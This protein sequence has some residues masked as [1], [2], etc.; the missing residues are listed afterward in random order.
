MVMTLPLVRSSRLFVAVLL[1][2]GLVA[3]ATDGFAQP[4]PRGGDRPVQRTLSRKEIYANLSNELGVKDA[5]AKAL[6]QSVEDRGFPPRETVV[7]LL[8][9]KARADRLIEEGKVSKGQGLDALHASVDFLVGLV[10][11]EKAGWL[12]LVQKTG[13]QVDLTAVVARANQI[14]GFFSERAG[15]SRTVPVRE[16]P[17]ALKPPASEKPAQETPAKQE[18]QEEQKDE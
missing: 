4:P 2:A 3:S 10:E 15:V 5:E 18:E 9:A 17:I 6:V 7:L 16:V 12:A 14:I 13:V 11:K 1:A 8:L